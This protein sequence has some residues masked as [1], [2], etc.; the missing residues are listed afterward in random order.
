MTILG[1]ILVFV[2]LI[3][4]LAT[5]ALII[6]VFVTRTNW[7]DGFQKVKKSYE[8][9]EA[10]KRAYAQ[11]LEEAKRSAETQIRNLQQ[12][13]RNSKQQE[14]QLQQQVAA[15]Q[16]NL[17]TVESRSKLVDKNVQEAT[18][19]LN[20]RKLEIDNLKKVL[21]D[22]EDRMVKME[23]QNTDY[24]N[25]AITA[26]ITAKSEQERNRQLLDQIAALTRDLERRQAPGG[27]GSAHVSSY[28]QRPPPDD[29][30]GTVLETDT[31][32]DLLTISI[33]SDAGVNVGNTLVVYRLKPRPEYVGSVTVIHADFHEAV[34]KPIKPLRAGPVQK[35]DIV[36]SR[37]LATGR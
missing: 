12:E 37:V 3:F 19:E 31:K 14:A 18:E 16:A 34:A 30:Q 2:N 24:R 4:S 8:V 22:K 26:E 10:N 1:K 5:G 32:S 25:K 17:G 7:E 35:G 27:N 36:A 6:M 9:S 13:V 11:E 21:K 33:G 28:G 29:V 20:R 15:E 23:G